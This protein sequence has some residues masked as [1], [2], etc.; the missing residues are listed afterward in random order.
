MGCNVRK[1]NQTHA[2]DPIDDEMA[3]L[4]NPRLQ[5]WRDY[6]CWSADTR[7]IFGLTPSSRA[8]VIAVS[9][10]RQSAIA[11]RTLMIRNGTHPPIET[12]D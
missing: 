4:F 7:L 2:P 3:P 8:T 11:Y 10:N 1:S 9:L 5:R 12:S 6:F